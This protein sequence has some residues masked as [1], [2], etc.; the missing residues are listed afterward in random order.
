MQ[1]H[2]FF[3]K[4]SLLHIDEYQNTENLKG[5]RKSFAINYD[6]TITRTMLQHQH[7][8]NYV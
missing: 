5:I 8:M 6:T 7:N 3:V 2:L 4:Q 1:I